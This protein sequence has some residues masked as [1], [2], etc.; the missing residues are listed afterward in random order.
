M[1]INVPKVPCKDALS[2][3]SEILSHFEGV[4]NPK[5]IKKIAT[6]LYG[7]VTSEI[8][9]KL[10]MD[11]IQAK[12]PVAKLT[13]CVGLITDAAFIIEQFVEE[14]NHGMILIKDEVYP[15]KIKTVDRWLTSKDRWTE[16]D[17]IDIQYKA[18]ED[19]LK[20]NN[21]TQFLGKVVL[22]PH[23]GFSGVPRLIELKA[24]RV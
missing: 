8:Q 24:E 16:E 19:W 22:Y 7:Q 5:K 1:T 3:E 20:T 18:A 10:C 17:E 4:T 12:D 13:R 15:V 11:L 6:K 2:L 21:K 23:F 9:K 14:G